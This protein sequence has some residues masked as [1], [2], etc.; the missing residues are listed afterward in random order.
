[1]RSVWPQIMEI[2]IC[3]GTVLGVGRQAT[4]H[5]YERHGALNRGRAMWERGFGWKAV[6][7][8]GW[9]LEGKEDVKGEA[10]DE[11]GR[12][13]TLHPQPTALSCLETK[14]QIK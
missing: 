8:A 14:R 7:F 10:R 13:C 5:Y 9:L 3:A 12:A 1:M 2:H 4:V 11:G 6:S